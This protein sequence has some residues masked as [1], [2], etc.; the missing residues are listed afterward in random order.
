VV[1]LQEIVVDGL[2]HVEAAEVVAGLSRLLA[3]DAAG[4]GRVVAA[5]IEEIADIMRAGAVEDLLAV[6]LVGLV[7]GR[8]ERRRRRAGE[9][10]EPIGG[11]RGEVDEPLSAWFDDAA[12]PVPHAEYALDVAAG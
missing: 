12:H 4:V 3:D 1:V 5:D 10:L 11:D 6:G 2:R 7:A 8:A 9:P